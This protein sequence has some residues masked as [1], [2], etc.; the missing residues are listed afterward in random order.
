MK[1]LKK[2]ASAA[3]AASM[4]LGS[5][6]ANVFAADKPLVEESSYINQAYPGF[7]VTNFRY[8]MSE[9]LNADRGDGTGERYNPVVGTTVQDEVY[10]TFAVECPRCHGDAVE[11]TPDAYQI[12]NPTASNEGIVSDLKVWLG[13]WSEESLYPAVKLSFDADNPGHTIVTFDIYQYYEV[14]RESG[15]CDFCGTYLTIPAWS[16]WKVN[17]VKL[18]ITVKPDPNTNFTVTYTDGVENEIVFPDEGYECKYGDKTPGFTGSTERPGY[19]F[20]GWAP[21]VASKV[22][23]SV[24]YTATWTKNPEQEEFTITYTDGLGGTVFGNETHGGLHAGDKTPSFNG[25]TER[26]GYVFKGWSPALKDT[27]SGNETYVAVWEEKKDPQPEEPGKK[28][29][30]PGIDKELFVNG[31]KV[32]NGVVDRNSEVTFKLTSNLPDALL[33]KYVTGW[34]SPDGKEENAVPEGEYVL[35]FHDVMDAAYTIR[36]GFTVKVGETPLAEGDYTVAAAED[37]CSFH[38]SM[39]LIA[40]YNDGKISKDD[41]KAARPVTVEYTATYNPEP[42]TGAFKNKAWVAGTDVPDKT[43]E[44]EADLFGIKAKKIDSKTKAALAG[45]EFTLWKDEAK[46]EKVADGI[47]DENGI[48]TFDNLTA[49][50]YYLEET[51]APAGYIRNTSLIEVVVNKDADEADGNVDFFVSRNVANAAAPHTGGAGTTLFT[52]GG[53]ALLGAAVLVA[54]SKKRKQAK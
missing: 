18:D 32:T 50:T 15:Y 28:E 13:G 42:T 19:T 35:T 12:S 5:G 30:M 49:G 27:V 39:D 8:P 7:G 29:S 21:A 46:T 9:P 2:V 40:L 48:V 34:H 44:V 31:N 26:E 38:I 14:Q 23:E 24:T 47:C 22:T 20:M 10:M 3:L 52:A 53:A 36:S 37:R 17:Q 16:G 54:V 11:Y 25:S 51:K 1:F 43:A 6:A 4:I 41:I 33:D 45:A